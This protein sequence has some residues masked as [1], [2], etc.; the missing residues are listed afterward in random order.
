MTEDADRALSPV[1]LMLLTGCAALGLLVKNDGRY[2]DS[3]LAEEFLVRGK[4]YYFGGWVRMLDQQ[5]VFRM[6]QAGRG[7]PHEPPDHVG[8]GPAKLPLRP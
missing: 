7:D 2:G 3:P 6:G 8:S 1:P 5:T 4:P